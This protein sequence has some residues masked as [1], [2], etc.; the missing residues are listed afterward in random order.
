MSARPTESAADFLF[1]EAALLDD[2]DL[3]GWL[4]LIDDSIDYRVPV[5]TIRDAADGS[6]FS[7][8]AFFYSEDFASLQTRVE[9]LQEEDAWCEHPRTRTRRMVSNV[10]VQEHNLN[11]IEVRS[12]LA[13]FCWRGD[14]VVPVILTGE[15]HD[16]LRIAD[17]SWR[18]ARRL[19]LLDSTVLGLQALSV[20]L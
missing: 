9:R 10:R 1:R 11:T 13:L 16:I 6:D 7:T 18:L 4:A 12:N 3:A 8:T 2:N 20:F 15:R 14:T 17:D 5:R 19:V